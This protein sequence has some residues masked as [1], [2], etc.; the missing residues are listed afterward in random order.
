M[1][2]TRHAVNSLQISLTP[3]PPLPLVTSMRKV[4][5]IMRFERGLQVVKLKETSKNRQNDIFEIFG[6]IDKRICT[7]FPKEQF[8]S[9]SNEENEESQNLLH[10]KRHL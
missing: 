7:L 8:I 10:W 5:I 2:S 6:E 3:L 1:A 9:P 4:N